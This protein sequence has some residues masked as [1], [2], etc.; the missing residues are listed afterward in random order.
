[1]NT[2]SQFPTG[3]A[4]CRGRR[5]TQVLA[6]CGVGAL[7]LGLAGTGGLALAQ[8]FRPLDLSGVELF[9]RYCAGVLSIYEV[10]FW[11][12]KRA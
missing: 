11:I 2:K 6:L 10:S 1:M 3:R 12:D 8:T 4:A 9:E 5:S 7:A